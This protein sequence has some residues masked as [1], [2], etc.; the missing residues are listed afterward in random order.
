MWLDVCG[1][2]FGFYGLFRVRGC[3]GGTPLI[4]LEKSSP[5]ADD[6]GSRD[7]GAPGGHAGEEADVGMCTK[8]WPVV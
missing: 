1:L 4:D 3:G 2:S 8:A 7:H 5:R 6:D